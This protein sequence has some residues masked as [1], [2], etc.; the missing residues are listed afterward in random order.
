MIMETARL[1]T[2]QTET[3]KRILKEVNTL[4]ANQL[5]EVYQLIH[6]LTTTTMLQNKKTDA[7]H[8]KIL[9]FAGAFNDM[10]DKDYT[11][12]TDK[13][14][15]TRKQLFDRNIEIYDSLLA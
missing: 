7:R 10:N 13:L 1:N 9:S 4:P 11:D 6:S 2:H 15:E 8:K 3:L 12:F 5:E 14:N